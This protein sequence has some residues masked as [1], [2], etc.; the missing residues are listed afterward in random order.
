MYAVVR[1]RGK[2]NIRP[3]IRDTLRMLRLNRI[4]HCVVVPENPHYLGMIKKVKDYVAWGRINQ[5]TLAL[6]IKKRG[7]L[8]GRHR[9]TEE[10]V[11][12]NTNYD[13]IEDLAKAIIANECQIKDLPKFKPVFR[14]HPPRKGHRGI[15]KTVPEGGELGFHEDINTLLYKMR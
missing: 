15:K 2:V 14:L 11:K 12:E 10:Y 5:E 7:R 6:I 13:S 3:E 4:N 8:E 1:I 9:I